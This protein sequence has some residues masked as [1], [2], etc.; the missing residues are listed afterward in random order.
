M[1]MGIVK[2]LAASEAASMWQLPSKIPPGSM[3]RHGRVDFS[4]D[5]GL[6]LNLHPPLGKDH[7]VEAAGNHHMI[8]LDL[9][10]HTGSLA[11]HQRLAG[12]DVAADPRLNPVSPR[13]LVC[14]LQGLGLVHETGPF[15]GFR[16]LSSSC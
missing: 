14:A 7:P 1:R 10:F 4:G 9:T 16:G 3:K 12:D 5:N 2:G 6:G 8:A 13:K 11:Q 15:A